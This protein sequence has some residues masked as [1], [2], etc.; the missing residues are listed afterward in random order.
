MEN[1]TGKYL[2]YAIGEIVLVVI[3]ILIALQIN[4]WNQER[5]DKKSEVQYLNNLKQD[6]KNQ[7]LEIDSQI[8]YEKKFLIHGESIFKPFNTSGEIRVDSV[9]LVAGNYINDR[10]TFKTINPTYAELINTGNMK[11]LRDEVFKNAL[12]AYQ[13]EILRITEVIKLNNSAFIDTELSPK[14]RELMPQFPFFKET[15]QIDTLRY[16]G[17]IANDKINWL[18]SITRE[19]LKD[20]QEL[21]HFMNLVSARYDYAWFD[22][23]LMA[24]QK[25]ETLRL[26]TMLDKL[27]TN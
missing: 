22:I 7:I 15:D 6:L 1:R 14:I 20:K 10:R 13:Q 3:G 8:A 23:Q 25:N 4:N 9:L 18:S 16:S 21:M 19:K 5:V 27:I 17:G 2:K 24:G 11:L 26:L 12:V